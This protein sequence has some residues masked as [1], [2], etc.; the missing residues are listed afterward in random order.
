[1]PRLLAALCMSLIAVSAACS[2]EQAAPDAQ[3]LPDELKKLQELSADLALRAAQAAARTP[4][5]DELTVEGP[6]SFVVKAASAVAEPDHVK[7]SVETDPKGEGRYRVAA[8]L[9]MLKDIA[10]AIA[11]ASNRTLL[12][13]KAIPP[14][15]LTE[16]V[17]VHVSNQRL[18][19]VLAIVMGLADM[20]YSL[21][22][23]H[24]IV[25]LPRRKGFATPA[26]YLSAKAI[27]AYTDAL[28]RDRKSSLAPSA[29]IAMGGL[30]LAEK[31]YAQ[32]LEEY[33]AAT[34]Q[35]PNAPEAAEAR[36]RMGQCL[37]A[38]SD[39]EHCRQELFRFLDAAPNSPLAPE[40]QLLIGRA[41]SAEGEL[42]EAAKWYRQAA[43]AESAPAAAEALMG[44]AQTRFDK[45]DYEQ[46]L[47]AYSTLVKQF[48]TSPHLPDVVF[49]Q[50][51]CLYRLKDYKRA[52]DTL[53]YLLTR[54]P[55][56]PFAER[57][58]FLL[59]DCFR[60]AD[61]KV[62]AV[63]AY[64]GALERFS[65]AEQAPA[66]RLALGTLYNE[67]A[68]HNLAVQTLGDL[69]DSRDKSDLRLQAL[70]QLAIAQRGSA[71]LIHAQKTYSLLAQEAAA[72][73]S[74]DATLSAANIALERGEYREALEL[75]VEL[76]R[77]NPAAE[78]RQAAYRG[79]A[80][81]YYKLGKPAKALE[82][83]Q[84]MPA[85]AGVDRPPVEPL[86]P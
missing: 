17:S 24:L 20:D 53:R 19:D 61:E 46:A 85:H 75:F 51:L 70:L 34:Q 69:A 82:L 8:S 84:G 83:F 36:F 49:Q 62:D 13:D 64:R 43:T 59:G 16:R 58:Y 73:L 48:P 57:G 44:M 80:Q 18:D 40:A 12:V 39:Y 30:Y 1:M 55:S 77:K 52:Q 23:H 72:P 29:R 47:K 71:D 68:L 32:A 56:S 31:R 9:A 65:R 26:Q 67:M 86:N 50:A 28:V 33:R 10:A 78:L 45:G 3:P 27:E 2:G 21:G 15:P 41:W 81:C 6:E 42:D 37:M 35:Q 11:I 76:L 79:A 25:V 66:A 4:G 22:P 14:Q 5:A 7:V 63:E 54:L 60:D 38:L 74:H